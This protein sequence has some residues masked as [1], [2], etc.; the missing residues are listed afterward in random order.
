MLTVGHY[1]YY[2]RGCVSHERHSSSGSFLSFV[3]G[4]CEKISYSVYFFRDYGLLRSSADKHSK[5][6]NLLEWLFETPH[7][8]LRYL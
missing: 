3:C 5:Q 4:T 6:V 8:L 7:E 1:N 2:F